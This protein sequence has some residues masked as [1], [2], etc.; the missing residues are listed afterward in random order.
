MTAKR[1]KAI[2]ESQKEKDQAGKQEFDVLHQIAFWGLAM[3]LFFPPYFRGLFFAP[4]QEKA[5]IFATLVFWLTFLW[6]WLQNDHKF[7]RNPLDW[8]ALALPVVYIISFFTAVNKGLAIN[9][10]IKNIL[11]FLTYWSASR[12]VRNAED[13]HKL[14]RVIYISA[15]GVALA[16]LATATEL[17]HINDGFNGQ[18]ISSTLQY[19]NA[20]AAYL[21]AVFFLGLYLWHRSNEQSL[22]VTEDLIDVTKN[23]ESKMAR[24]NPAG[25]LFACGNF[26]LLTVLIGSKS[27]AGLLVFGLVF[28]IYLIGAGNEKR[29]KASLISGYLAVIAYIVI[30]KFIFLA[31]NK[32][33]DT[34]WLWI[35]G[36]LVLALAGQLAFTLLNKH[37]FNMWAVNSKKYLLVFTVLAAVVVVAGGVWAFGQPQILEKITSQQYLKTAYQRLYYIKSAMD[38]ITERPLFGWGGGGWKEA[39]ESYL[40]Y[41]YITRE[42]HS[43]YFQVGVEIG[44]IGA[45][46]VLG[47]W[48][49]FLFSAF[50]LF[51]NDKENALQRQLAWLFLIVFLMIAG[52]SL[53]DFD[54]SLSSITLVLWV[55]FGMTI[56]LLKP[57]HVDTRLRAKQVAI[58]YVPIVGS[59]VALLVV[60]LTCTTL[61][62]AKK[63]ADQGVLYLR[64]NNPTMGMQ[65]LERAIA[66]NPFDA[67]NRVTLSQVY[68]GLGKSD[69]ALTEA[70][71]AVELSPYRFEVRNNLINV[72]IASGNNELAA[73]ENEN[74]LKLAPNNIESYEAYAQNYVNIGIRELMSGQK[75]AARGRFNKATSVVKT[76][77][78]HAASLTETDHKMWQGPK[79]DVNDKIQLNL[80]QTYY[81]LGNFTKAQEYLQKAANSKDKNNK[82]QALLWLALANDKKGQVEKANKLIDQAQKFNSEITQQYS[83]LRKIPVL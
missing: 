37:V 79:L 59:S 14:L 42:V 52:H 11:Y 63:L 78:D 15:I 2:K 43:Y 74:I 35:V 65:N 32:Q 57:G 13:V 34:A 53:I 6:R 29:L 4:E 76:V 51:R 81:F 72:A 49:S 16:G 10:V 46:S 33:Y 12:L 44:V 55:I 64:A 71:R 47:I 7:L 80:G 27:R 82:G 5:L 66:G 26:L 3:L 50:R 20:L 45:I 83:N 38:M 58:N 21:A 62:H 77:N 67:N 31:Q 73:V 70:R 17:I 28:L 68:S 69:N 40:S 1:K 36:G 75:D 48:L 60:I 9:E 61:L 24:L 19:H 25:Y 22:I 23:Y 54:L 18:Y 41:R 30:S 56:G 39:Y 8:F